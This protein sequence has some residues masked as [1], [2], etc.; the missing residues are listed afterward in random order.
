MD[1]DGNS[2]KSKVRGKK[3]ISLLRTYFYINR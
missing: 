1:A 3:L 2:S